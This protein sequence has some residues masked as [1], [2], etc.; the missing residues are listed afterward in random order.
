MT[1]RATFKA[2]LSLVL[3]KAFTALADWVERRERDA[4]VA[5]RERAEADARAARGD[6]ERLERMTDAPHIVDADDA[7]RRMRERKPGTR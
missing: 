5:D 6:L 1:W 3:G 4:L 7:K 2:F